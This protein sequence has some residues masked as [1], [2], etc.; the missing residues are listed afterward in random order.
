VAHRSHR[1]EKYKL[2]VTCPNELFV[3]SVPVPP[4]H[5]K[6]CINVLHYERT[7]MHYVTH[8]SH[9]MQKHKFNITCPGVVSGPHELEKLCVDLSCH[10]R[11]R[12]QYVTHKSHQ[13][14]KHKFGIMCPSSLFV[15]SVPVPPEH[16]KRCVK[17]SRTGRIECT[18]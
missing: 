16:E 17:V 5:E 2:D 8:R 7:R 10:R 6:C 9:R 4:K 3:E 15:E 12:T 14:E 18:T 13:M 11:T 1:M